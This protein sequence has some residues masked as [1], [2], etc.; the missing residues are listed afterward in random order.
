MEDDIIKQLKDALEELQEKMDNLV[1]LFSTLDKKVL[2]KP[3][4]NSSDTLELNIDDLN[5]IEVTK[6]EFL[7][8]INEI[9][10][11]SQHRI[12]LTVPRITDLEDLELYNVRSSVN[13]KIACY[14]D[15]GFDVDLRIVRELESFENIEIRNYKY[16]DRW[17]IFRDGKE[18]LCVII[19]AEESNYLFFRS[20]DD[21]HIKILSYLATDPWLRS[22]KI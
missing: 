1:I 14:I 3:K 4:D 15:T 5:K 19:G 7:P 18:L 10:E 11:K 12:M 21:S 20:E 9:L 6:A 8:K 13:I 16:Q 22:K 17:V 2:S